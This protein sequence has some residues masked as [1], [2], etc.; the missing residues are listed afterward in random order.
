MLILEPKIAAFKPTIQVIQASLVARGLVSGHPRG[1]PG[2]C[3][4]AVGGVGW[5]P[6]RGRRT[7]QISEIAPAANVNLASKKIQ[8]YWSTIGHPIPKKS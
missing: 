5:L 6:T 4:A 2:W 7:G 8:N 3:G 1:R